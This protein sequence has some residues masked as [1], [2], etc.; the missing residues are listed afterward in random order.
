MKKQIE[1]CLTLYAF[2]SEYTT[3]RYTLEDCLAKAHELGYT[4]IELVASQMVPGYPNPSR[5][6]M[7]EFAAMLKKYE[8]Q[9]VCYS[10]Y[11]DMGIHSDRDLTED[12]IIQFTLNDMTYAKYMGFQLVRTQ[13]AISP[14]IFRAMQPYAKTIGMPLTIEMHAPHTPDVPEWKEYLE[15]MKNSEGWLGVVPD[16]SGRRSKRL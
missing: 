14:K 6:W 1:L 2:S 5:E 16:F 4:G 7:D 3:G 10:A 15:I 8:L 13:H 12:E 11:I 9:P